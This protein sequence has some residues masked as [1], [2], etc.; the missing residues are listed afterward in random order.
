MPARNIER[1]NEGN[2]QR[3]AYR[4]DSQKLAGF[5]WHRSPAVKA[6]IAS[7]PN[8]ER[9]QIQDEH[10]EHHQRMVECQKHRSQNARGDFN[11]VDY[12]GEFLA[13][14]ESDYIKIS[15]YSGK[16]LFVDHV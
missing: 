10:G 2:D 11:V 4:P 15:F 1:D 5:L 16:F 9:Q 6:A 13:R 14:I 3:G 7:R 12:I 8:D